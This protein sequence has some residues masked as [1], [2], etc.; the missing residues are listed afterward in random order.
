[1]PAVLL[2]CMCVCV[3]VGVAIMLI[4]PTIS[5]HLDVLSAQH[6]AQL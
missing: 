4:K 2:L 5:Q 6:S 3:C 1:M